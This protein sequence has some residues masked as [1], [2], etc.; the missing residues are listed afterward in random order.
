MISKAKSRQ[1]KKEITYELFETCFF[2]NNKTLN[3]FKI[4]FVQLI[5]LSIFDVCRN[6]SILNDWKTFHTASEFTGRYDQLN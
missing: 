5:L 4:F 6:I 3:I 2:R 1:K